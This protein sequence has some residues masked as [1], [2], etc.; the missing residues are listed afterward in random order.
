MAVFVW[1]EHRATAPLVPPRLFRIRSV[2][3]G[4]TTV[5]LSFFA[6][7]AVLFFV[8]LFLQNVQGLSAVATGTRTL[9]LTLAFA[10]TSIRAARITMRLGPGPTIT[11]GMLLVSGALLGM[12]LL[13]PNS[14]YAVLFPTLAC[15][16]V[17]LGLVVVASAEAIVGSVPVD[18]AGLAGGLQATASQLGGV[19]G[20]S[21]L[22]S[23]VAAR[24]SGVLAARLASAGVG[25]VMTHHALAHAA[26]VG[27]GLSVSTASAVS[28]AS[29]AAFISGFHLA[30][31]IGSA[32]AFVGSL[33]GPFIRR[34]ELT[35]VV[36]VH[37]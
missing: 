9:A 34:N 31:L 1:V 18:D 7:F 33:A 36:A 19:L 15:L 16:G 28:Q 6:L 13:E 22:G 14:G 37:L 8:S 30:L 29:H 35:G 32:V 26:L 3:L 5:T 17:G 23:V 12:T 24:A 20:A 10:L 2:S 25:P 21:V 4:S 27:Q 11:I